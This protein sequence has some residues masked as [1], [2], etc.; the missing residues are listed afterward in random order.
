MEAELRN[1]VN[2]ID[3]TL[4]GAKKT[5]ASRPSSNLR[6][7]ENYSSTM[8]KILE[9]L[10]LILLKR[11]YDESVGAPF[12]NCP[13]CNH[14]VNFRGSLKLKKK[15]KRAILFS[16]SF[17]D[18]ETRFSLSS[19]VENMIGANSPIKGSALDPIPVVEGT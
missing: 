15:K 19:L 16:C 3:Q 5:N 6:K 11:E 7:E 12:V 1:R 13:Q 18:E 10:D 4:G 2:E 9:S 8:Q 14:K 17:C